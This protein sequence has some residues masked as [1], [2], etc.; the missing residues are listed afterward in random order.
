MKE[1]RGLSM[2]RAPGAPKPLGYTRKT[3]GTRKFRI[4]FYRWPPGS[5][6][7]MQKP[8]RARTIYAAS[9]KQAGAHAVNLVYNGKKGLKAQTR[10]YVH[11]GSIQ[12]PIAVRGMARPKKGPPNNLRPYTKK[13]KVRS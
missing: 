6:A 8:L 5:L 3:P 11:R 9:A 10:V 12:G 1:H 13:K 2:G 7:D 4:E